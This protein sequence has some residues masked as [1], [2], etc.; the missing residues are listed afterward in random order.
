MDGNYQHNVTNKL[1]L[2][3]SGGADGFPL[4]IATCQLLVGVLYALFL[5]VAPDA[6]EKPSIT[7]RDWLATLPVSFAAA[8]AHAASVFALSA[9]AM[10]FAQIVKASEPIFAALI[11]TVFYA[12]KVSS[13]KWLC[14]LPI[15][16]GVALSSVAELDFTWAALFSASLANFFAAV[17]GNENMK[18]LAAEGIKDR[19]GCVGNQYAITTI[20]AFFFIMPLAIFRE[21]HKFDAFLELCKSNREVFWS[22]LLSGWWFYIYNEIA[23]I[24]IKKTGPL[25]QSIANTAKRAVIIIVGA[26]VLG[27]SLNPLKLIGCTIA[28]GGV[29]LYSAIDKLVNY[30]VGSAVVL[31]EGRMSVKDIKVSKDVTAAERTFPPSKMQPLAK[32]GAT[33]SNK[34]SSSSTAS[35]CCTLPE[36]NFQEPDPESGSLSDSSRSSSSNSLDQ[37]HGKLSARRKLVAPLE[38]LRKFVLVP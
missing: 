17:R 1:A 23:T 20:N 13:A 4:T 7:F 33:P 27:E 31:E 36:L 19:L 2:V 29:F 25:T 3:R 9:G 10:S 15:I 6:R 26:A 35:T 24:I 12:S 8:C 16:G 32:L 34:A 28:I 18:L 5:W 11:G 38:V 22:I 37:L 21:G 30:S 14:L